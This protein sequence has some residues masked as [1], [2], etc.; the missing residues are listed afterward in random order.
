MNTFSNYH[1]G[2]LESKGSTLKTS[3][4]APAIIFSLMAVTTS[5]STTD[6]PLPILVNIAVGFIFLNAFILNN[7]SVAGVK[8]KAFTI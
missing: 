8:G 6:Y 5:S 1:K 2:L 7:L 4:V 3:K